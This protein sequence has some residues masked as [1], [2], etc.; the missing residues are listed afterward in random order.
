MEDGC[1]IVL[2]A[3]ALFELIAVLRSIGIVLGGWLILWSAFSTIR[4]LQGR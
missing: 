4:L 1:D 2:G 3:R